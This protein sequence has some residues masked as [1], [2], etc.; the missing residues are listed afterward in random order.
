MSFIRGNDSS[1]RAAIFE[2]CG[3]IC[4][5]CGLD[6]NWLASQLFPRQPPTEMRS[7]ALAAHPWSR[8]AYCFGDLYDLDHIVPVVKGGGQKGDQNLRVLCK[9]CHRKVT[10]ELAGQRRRLPSKRYQSF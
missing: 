9:G 2:A 6:I 3:G 10:K 8:K 5:L 4:A 1:R 7:R